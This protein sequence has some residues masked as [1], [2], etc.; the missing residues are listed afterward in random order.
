LIHLLVKLLES[1]GL[2]FG[3]FRL[4]D[5]LSFTTLLAALTALIVQMAFGHRLIVLLYRRKFRDTG[6][7]YVALDTSSKR[8]TPTGGGLL[9]VLSTMVAVLLWARLHNPYL[10][11][12][13][14]AF[15]YFGLVGFLDDFQKV[16][17]KSSLYGLSQ[18]A[19][20]VM[21]L[22]YI[23][24]F[25][26]FF[27]SPLNPV[28]A[29]VR[30]KLFIPF[31]KNALTDLGPALFAAFIIFA[32]FSIL[33]AVNITDGLDGLVSGPSILTVAMFGIFGY[34]IG[35]KVMAAYLL[36]PYFP[37][38]GELSVFCGALVGALFGFLWYNT[39][40]AEVFM[41]DTGSLA[42]GGSMAVL[43]FLTRQEMLFPIVGGVFV[44]M[45]ASSLVQEKV[46]MRLGRRILLRA[47]IHHSLTYRGIAEP[48]V[49][50][51]IWIVSIM[52][53]ILAALSIKLR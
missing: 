31:V 47:P 41:G 17:L 37:G 29:P 46:G 49:V 4:F 24:P 1:F 26:I 53:A 33:N 42:L 32:F 45:I 7:E 6:G 9:I 39:Y 38:S 48:K 10:W 3:F 8:G 34:I 13:C 25:A 30:T 28:P 19:K 51:R 22:L 27:V 18:L 14:S 2:S 43:A 20:T 21:Q 36:F 44:A 12:V 40:P 35:N 11:I 52:L 23:V 50:I 15:L 5:Y 16:R